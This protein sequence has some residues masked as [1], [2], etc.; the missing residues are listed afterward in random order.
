MN[1]D[2]IFEKITDLI[3]TYAPK[4]VGAILVWIVGNWIIKGLVKTF[5]KMLDKSKTD[6]SL[7]PFLKSIINAAL[8]VM[9]VISVLTMIC[10]EMTSFVAILGAAGLAIG[11]AISGTLQNLSL[12]HI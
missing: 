1:V 4:L 8:K 2:Y 6:E 3:V 7:K 11:M 10:I 12:I 9:L 5:T